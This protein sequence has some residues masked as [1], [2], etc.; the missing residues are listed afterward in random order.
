SNLFTKS[1][2]TFQFVLSIVL[3][4]S[5]I[6][7]LQQTR[8]LISKDPGFNKENVI[9]IDAAETNP[10]QVFPLFKQ[11]LMNHPGILGVT[12]SVAG[13]GAGQDLLGYSDKN[14]SIDINIIDRDYLKVFG[15]KLMAGKNFEPG[16]VNDSMKPMIINETMMKAFGWNAQTAVGQQIK[17]FQ[18][19]S[20]MVVG[21]VKNFNYRALSE[22]VKNQA[23]IS[24]ND[25]G[26]IHFYVRV[27]AGN[28]A[29]ALGVI[30]NAWNFAM[31]GIPLKYSFLDEDVNDY[32]NAEQRW[33]NMVG[34]AG[35]ISI[36]LASLGLFGLA[37][38]TTINRT[39][40]IGLRKVL[41]ASVPNI[42]NL[43][44]KDFLKLILLSF[45]IASPVAWYFMSKWLQDYANRIHIS[46][47][48]F[49]FA[50]AFAMVTALITIS[51]Q[52]IKAAAANPVKSLRTE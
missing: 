38:L 3:I 45:I 20:A 30:Q 34:W 19:K 9:A 44:L 51:F 24:S 22:G 47:T 35:G 15:L 36:F 23:F 42:I 50:G 2:V 52:A 26:Y 27:S 14:L 4:I 10:N 8:Y 28:P 13:L 12:S 7:I 6:I 17:G 41:G 49:V 31:P 29:N 48:V 11:S 46:W 25:Q 21:V 33:S 16:P 40:E 39:K 43:V 32:Y 18:H 5:T 1:L 37:A